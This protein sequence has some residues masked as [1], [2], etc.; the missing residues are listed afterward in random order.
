MQNVAILVWVFGAL[1]IAGGVAGYVKAQSKA[2]LF[3][4]LASGTLLLLC[5]YAIFQGKVIGL[6]VGTGIALALLVIMGRRFLA[7]KKFM[8]AG[9]VAVLAL[10]VAVVLGMALFG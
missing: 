8:P 6:R 10:V 3:S 9:L 1:V 2:S 5:G 7:T 4:G